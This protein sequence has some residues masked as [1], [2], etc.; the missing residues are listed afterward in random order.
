MARK[1]EDEGPE[2]PGVREDSGEMHGDVQLAGETE[3]GKINQKMVLAEEG[4]IKQRTRDFCNPEKMIRLVVAGERDGDGALAV[5]ADG[6][7]IGGNE[8]GRP[9]GGGAI[10]G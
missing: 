9:V 7:S 2:P 1:S 8:D 6:G 10:R 5:S 3:A 4:G